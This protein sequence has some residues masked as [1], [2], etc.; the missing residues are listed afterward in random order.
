ML[1]SEAHLRPE[2]GRVCWQEITWRYSGSIRHDQDSNQARERERERERVEKLLCSELNR[3]KDDGGH[4]T[5]IPVNL[6]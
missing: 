4:V 5:L 1:S 6:V 3:V 2:F